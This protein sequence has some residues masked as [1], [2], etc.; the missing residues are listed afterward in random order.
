MPHTSKDI[1]TIGHSNRESNE[2]LDLLQNSQIEL[3]VDVRRFPASRAQ[4]QFNSD[5]FAEALGERG[6]DYVHL[7]ALGGRRSTRLPDSPNTAWRVDSFNRYADYMATP[8][9]QAGLEELMRLAGERRVAIMC[10]E[11]V[12]WRC[13][14]RLIGDSLLVRGWQ[15]HDIISAGAPKPHALTPFAQFNDGRLTYPAENLASA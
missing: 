15:V 1:W 11:A 10:S 14:R 2:L 6:I 8:D 9:F 4:P 12:P 7:L 13:H 5:V 3:L